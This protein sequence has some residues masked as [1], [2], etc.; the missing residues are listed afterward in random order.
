VGDAY[1]SARGH[2]PRTLKLL[3][4]ALVWAKELGQLERAHYLATKLGDSYR[5]LYH[6]YNAALTSYEEGIQLARLLKNVSR[7]AIVTSLEAVMRYEMGQ[8]T[9]EQFE[10]A[11]KLAQQANDDFAICQVLLNQGYI[12]WTQKDWRSVEKLNNKQ[13]EI[14]YALHQNSDV[15]QSK[16]D[17][18]LFFALLNLGEAKRKLGFFDEAL[19][20]RVQALEIADKRDNQLWRAY[21]FQELAELYTDSQQVRKAESYLRQ[22]LALYKENHAQAEV[23]QVESILSNLSMKEEFTPN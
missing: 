11:Y 17:D 13:L 16:V 5:E 19:S 9:R 20:L 22:A 7:E 1:F 18:F 6:D 4:K 12:A 23:I 14:M 8:P 2:T 15:E 3:E 21:V 10:H